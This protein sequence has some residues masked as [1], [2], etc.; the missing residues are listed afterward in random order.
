MTKII[1]I[2]NPLMGDDGAGILAVER[3]SQMP[4]PDDVEVI[5]GGT[6][7]ITLLHL[8]EDAQR[9]IL[10]DAVDMDKAPGTIVCF[11]PDEVR[12]AGGEAH[13]SLHEAGLAPVLEL[14]RAMGPLPPI[15]LF[16]IQPECVSRRIGLSPTLAQALPFLVAAVKDGL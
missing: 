5:D 4:L 10:I 11:S 13:L 3:L 1:G 15:T 12:M 2:G 7:G 16:G 8:M 9:V 6:G 14:G